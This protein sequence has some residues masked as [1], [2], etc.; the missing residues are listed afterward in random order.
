MRHRWQKSSAA[1][2]KNIYLIK[3]ERKTKF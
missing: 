1:V 2:A 3:L